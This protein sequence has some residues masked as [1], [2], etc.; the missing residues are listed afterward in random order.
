MGIS[1]IP[2]IALAPEIPGLCTVPIKSPGLIRHIGVAVISR[3]DRPHVTMLIHAL[4]E[5]AMQ[6]H[7]GR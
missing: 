3:S 4:L 2:S 5:Q 6:Q 1:L 7:K